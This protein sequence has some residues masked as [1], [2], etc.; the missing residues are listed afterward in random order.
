MEDYSDDNYEQNYEEGYSNED[1]NSEFSNDYRD[2]YSNSKRS[3]SSSSNKNSP[4]EEEEEEINLEYKDEWNVFT[5]TSNIG[6]QDKEA[7]SSID[8]SQKK[9]LKTAN[10]AIQEINDSST[11]YKLS[12]DKFFSFLMKTKIKDR[13]IYLLNAKLLL[14]CYLFDLSGEFFTNENFKKFLTKISFM[15]VSDIDLYRYLLLLKSGE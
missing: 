3:S 5:R 6:I 1:N 8:N 2:S 10:A 4:I 7:K 15:D 11:K 12:F 14:A 9:W 13:N